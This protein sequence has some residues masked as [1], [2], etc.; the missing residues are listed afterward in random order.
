MYSKDR[1][2]SHES[3]TAVFILNSWKISIHLALIKKELDLNTN[4]FYQWIFFQP[5]VYW[6]SI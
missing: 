6:K 1:S 2:F 5:L 3:T 4:K